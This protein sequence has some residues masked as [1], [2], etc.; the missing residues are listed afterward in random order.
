ML[1]V[2]DT[3]DCSLLGDVERR[4]ATDAHHRCVAGTTHRRRRGIDGSQRRL[5][6]RHQVD[7]HVPGPQRL[8]H[9]VDVTGGLHSLIGDD[10]HVRTSETVESVIEAGESI[11]THQGP[12][13][14]TDL[15]TGIRR[16]NRNNC[17][18]N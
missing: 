16:H 13:H 9:S 8:D 12:R 7:G 14:T 10:D 4:T 3:D 2:T 5:A 6:P 1:R 17:T 11:D 18:R 15:V